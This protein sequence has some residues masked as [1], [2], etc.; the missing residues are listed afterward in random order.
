MVE[1]SKE[2]LQPAEAP[3]IA[4]AAAAPKTAV[5]AKPG[6]PAGATPAAAPA[7]TGAT[8][9]IDDFARLDL[10]VA[11]IVEAEAV[12]EADK[13]LRLKLDLGDGTRQ[14]FAGIKSSYD[15]AQL[16]GRLTVM[17][18][19]LAP[20]K[21]RFGLSEGM[22]LAASDERGGPFLLAL[23]AGAEPGMKVK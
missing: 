13:L 23:D 18:A 11:R 6:M 7:T 19:N 8:I 1:A 3:S 2:T 21:M 17:V 10:R 4:S 16:V 9:S 15:P 14:V 5:P 12:P 20:R 22:I